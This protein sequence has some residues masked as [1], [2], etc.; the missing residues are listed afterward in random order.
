M[1]ERH[2]NAH[3]VFVCQRHG[4]G[5]KPRVVDDIEM[6]QR[7]TFGLAGGAAGELDIDRIIRVER[8]RQ[9]F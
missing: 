4:L 2:R 8:G 1:V 6:R 5:G 9:I 3:A 7:G